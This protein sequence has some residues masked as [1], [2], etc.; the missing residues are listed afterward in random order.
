MSLVCRSVK[1]APSVTMYCSVPTLVLSIV[2]SYT[3]DRTPSATVYQTLE[4]VLRAVPRQSLRA[5]SKKDIV[6][7]PP[8]AVTAGCATAA[9]AGVAAASAQVSMHKAVAGGASHRSP[10][11]PACADPAIGTSRSAE[12]EC[13][14][15]PAP[16]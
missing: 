3:S 11:L 5:R 14:L 4:P 16:L 9:P 13:V 8:G 10:R 7:G 6:P 12:I 2:G 1:V 15:R